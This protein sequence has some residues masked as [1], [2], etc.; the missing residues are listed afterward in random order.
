MR[1]PLACFC[2]T[3]SFISS[4]KYI[5]KNC[6]R[7][8]RRAQGLLKV[9]FNKLYALVLEE[10]VERSPMAYICKNCKRNLR[11]PKRIYKVL[12]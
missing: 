5:C 10:G 4:C 2:G 7:I 8:L 9:C 6:K 12:S 3:A 1:G 11:G